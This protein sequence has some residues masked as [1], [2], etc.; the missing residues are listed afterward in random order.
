V[1]DE[2]EQRCCGCSL[3]ALVMSC[4]GVMT[5]VELK[6]TSSLAFAAG[7]KPEGTTFC[8]CAKATNAAATNEEEKYILCC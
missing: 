1:L 2:V 8:A 7:A 3:P 4:P 6:K 5:I